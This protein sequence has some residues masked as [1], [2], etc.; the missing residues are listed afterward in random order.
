MIGACAE[1]ER[2]EGQ[3][4]SGGGIRGRQPLLGEVYSR[5]RGK[6]GFREARS[7]RLVGPDVPDYEA[8]RGPPVP[9]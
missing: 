1:D 3:N 7:L 9:M 8:E 5:N 2:L 6:R 4:G